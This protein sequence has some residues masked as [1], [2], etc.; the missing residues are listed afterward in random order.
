MLVNHL[1]W[2]FLDCWVQK[3]EIDP[4][5]DGTQW[6]IVYCYVRQLLRKSLCELR[7]W[8]TSSKLSLSLFLT[9]KTFC[10]LTGRWAEHLIVVATLGR[11]V[12]GME[13]VG[14]KICHTVLCPFSIH[15]SW[16][17]HPSD[18]V[19]SLTCNSICSFYLTSRWALDRRR[20]SR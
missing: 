10:F 2:N 3:P 6:P 13:T 16:F 19:T 8:V 17:K 20:S 14:I 11:V 4:I 18:P 15:Q 7:T 9:R 5:S 1:K 12:T